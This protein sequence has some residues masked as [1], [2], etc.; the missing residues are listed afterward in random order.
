MAG[1]HFLMNTLLPDGE[2]IRN[3]YIEG[4]EWQI[5][6][7][8]L[9]GMALWASKDLY[10]KWC[11]SGLV[12]D[13]FFM[14]YEQ[15]FILTCAAGSILSSAASG[16]YTSSSTGAESFAKALHASLRKTDRP[17]ADGIYIERFSSVLPTYREKN[18][19]PP[20]RILGRWITRG[21][22]ISICDTARVK[23]YAEYLS[24]AARL[25]ILA[26]FGLT[27]QTE[28]E[29]DTILA[30]PSNA[31]EAEKKEPDFTGERQRRPRGEGPFELPGRE[32]LERFFREE[33][34]DIID[35]EE[36]YKKFGVGFPGATILYGP[37]GSGKTFAVEKFADYLGWPV[38]RVNSGTIGSK[39]VHETSK[40]ISAA[41]DAAIRNA[42]SVLIIDE[43]ESFLSSRDYSTG[44]GQIHA[45]EVDEFLRRI[46]EAAE[47]RV[48]LF[49]MTNMLGAIDEAVKRKG[50]FDHE[51][52]VDMPSAAEVEAVLENSLAKLPVEGALPL[53]EIAETL[54]GRPLSDTAFVLTEAGKISV[55]AGKKGIDAASLREACGKI[56]PIK[57]KRKIGF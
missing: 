37:S 15:G 7:L 51:I 14:D 20:D 30:K 35:R 44:G 17:L 56:A 13:G 40:L 43:M 41:F 50:R 36:E 54:A 39:W 52:L 4:Q 2:R 10:N 32:K 55:R 47:N 53:S 22:N 48:L 1:S 49:G 19:V 38:F 28:G 34:L 12:E 42:P 8:Q 9:G 6:T 25:R 27:E 31:V 3:L 16:P 29:G 23:R 33:I 18:A 24:D 11:G 45:E 21:M 57:K 26:L 5:Y 46:P